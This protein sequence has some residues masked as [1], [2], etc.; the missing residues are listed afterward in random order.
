MRRYLVVRTD[1]RRKDFILRELDAGR[2]RQGWG[3]KPEQDLRVLRERVTSGTKLTDDEA[4]AW[5]NRRLLD[6]EGDGLK[7]GDI[8][9]VPNIP[10]QGRWALARVVG[11]YRYDPP[12]TEAGVGSDYAHVVPVEAIFRRCSEKSASATSVEP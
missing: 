4:A 1:K 6:T 7:P 2:L 3:S 9:I 12:P 10:D 11:P 5:R 8:V